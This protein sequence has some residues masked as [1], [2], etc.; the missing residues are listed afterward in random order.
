MS[1]EGFGPGETKWMVAGRNTDAFLEDPEVIMVVLCSAFP[2]LAVGN[3]S[4]LE[5]GTTRLRVMMVTSLQPSALW[6]KRLEQVSDLLGA[7]WAIGPA[8]LFVTPATSCDNCAWCPQFVKEKNCQLRQPPPVD[9][10]RTVVVQLA[11]NFWYI[12]FQSRWTTGRVV[13]RTISPIQARTWLRL[14][15]QRPQT[16]LSTSAAFASRS[17]V[18]PGRPSLPSVWAP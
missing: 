9:R 2:K 15:Q 18:S 8:C 14:Y 10:A 17:S 4:I 3:H 5:G 6:G 1:G 16:A 12:C 11:G 13:P 7:F